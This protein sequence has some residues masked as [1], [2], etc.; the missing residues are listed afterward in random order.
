MIPYIDTHCHLDLF[1]DIQEAPLREDVDEIKT[2]SVTNAPYLFAHNRKLFGD[3]KNIRI[4]IGLHPELASQFH[5]Q[6]N[7][8]KSGLQDTKYIGEI[9]LDGSPQLSHTYPLQKKL[10]QDILLAVRK[11]DDK[12]LTVHSRNAAFDTIALLNAH[13]KNSKCKIILHWYSGDL[14]NIEQAN[15]IGCYFS[16]NHKMVTTKKGRDII[17]KVPLE[18]ILTETDAPFTFDKTITNRLQSLS[19][20]ISE[21]A[22]IH[23]NSHQ[24]MQQII[25]MNFH[26]LLS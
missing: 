14:K 22:K 9:G 26:R 23:G 2:I 12:I 4:A 6:I 18:R 24:E 8:L 17:A 13:L 19:L 3:A 16:V 20:T 1:P 21:L 15:D 7:V 11:V 25:Y 5:D 10:F